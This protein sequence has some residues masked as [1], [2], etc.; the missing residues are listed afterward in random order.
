MEV[1]AD[2]LYG[3]GGGAV[4]VFVAGEFGDVGEALLA[5]DFFDGFAG[6]VG[7]E[8]LELGAEGEH[9]YGLLC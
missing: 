5:L 9:W 1:V 6:G 8:G 2:G 4:G 7:L 3:A